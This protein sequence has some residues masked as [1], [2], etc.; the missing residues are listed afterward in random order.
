MGTTVPS[1]F[2]K[3]IAATDY[4]DWLL[5]GFH[6]AGSVIMSFYFTVADETASFRGKIETSAQ[7]QLLLGGFSGSRYFVSSEMTRT[8]GPVWAAGA[9][10]C[11]KCRFGHF[12]TAALHFKWG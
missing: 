7:E 8:E 3:L 5:G 12:N 2:Q 6:P 9:K 10:L 11:R 1:E 4:S